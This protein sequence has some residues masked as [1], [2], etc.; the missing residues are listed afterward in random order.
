VDENRQDWNLRN[1]HLIS[2]VLKGTSNYLTTTLFHQRAFIAVSAGVGKK[3]HNIFCSIGKG[4]GNPES[5]I[6][7]W[8]V[9]YESI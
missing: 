1:N 6:T 2:M 7:S 5:L 3:G 4:V 9:G 8:W